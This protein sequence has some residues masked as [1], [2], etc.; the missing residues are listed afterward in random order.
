MLCRICA[1]ARGGALQ[2]SGL[3][4][5]GWRLG[6]LCR[7]RVRTHMDYRG[8]S[9]I[10]NTDYRGTSLIRNGFRFMVWWADA[11]RRSGFV[12]VLGLRAFSI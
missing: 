2:N 3:G 11:R 5:R 12:F 8:T 6:L 1:T 9:L 10:R 4:F 7:A